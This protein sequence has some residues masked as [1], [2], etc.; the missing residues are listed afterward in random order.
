MKFKHL[1]IASLALM[2]GASSANA[3][4]VPGDYFIQNVESGRFLNGAN[5]WGTKASVTKHGQKMTIAVSGS[6]YTIDSHI[7]NGS[8][9]NFLAAGDNTYTDGV[10]ATHTITDLGD[11]TFSIKDT[12]NKY[13]I[14]NDGTKVNFAADNADANTAKWKF[15]SMDD[16][17]ALMGTAKVQAPVDATYYIGDA[18]FSRN[19]Q[20]YSNWVWAWGESN[21]KQNH[22]K[23]GNN[24]NNVV[25]SFHA[26][27]SLTQ[28]ITVPNGVYAVTAQGFYRQDG[29]NNNDLPYFFANDE[30]KQL[31]LKTGSEN[32]MADA[33]TSFSNDLY[34][35]EPIYVKVTDGTLNIGVNNMNNDALWVIFDNF[36]MKYYG[37]VTIAEV[38]LAEY[39]KAYNEAMDAVNAINQEY[40]SEADKAALNTLVTENTVDLASATQEQLETAAANLTAAVPTYAYK[41]QVGALA[42]MGDNT[43]F[44]S[45][46]VNPSFETGNMSGWTNNSNGGMW[47]MMTR[48]NA[49]DPKVGN[50]WIEKYAKDGRLDISQVVRGL[51]MGQYRVSV[52]ALDQ[53]SKTKLVAQCGDT[54]V[55]TLIAGG[56]K[57]TYTA[58]I[59]LD[60]NSDLTIGLY[61]DAHNTNSWVGV[62]NFQLTYLTSELPALPATASGVMNATVEQ[63]QADA[64]AAYNANKSI[65]TYNAAVAAIDA[66]QKSVAMYAANATALVNQKALIDG[67]NVYAAE[68][69][70]AYVT[71]YEAAKTAH[72]NRTATE[73]VVNPNLATGWHAST[74]YNFLLTPWTF[75]GEAC[76]EFA[77]D[78]HINTWSTEGDNDGSNFQVPFFEFWI[79][80]GENLPNKELAANV[81]G[82]ENGLYS[83]SA[84]VRVRAKNGVAANEATGI[85]L[86]VND[87]SVIDATEGA[88]VGA[89]QFTLANVTAEGLVKDG[90][91]NIKL[92][93][94]NT[95][96][97]W[98]AFKNV[99]YNKVRD[100]LPEE[101]IVYATTEEIA[102]FN[103]AIAAAE[104]KT[105]GFAEGEYAP[106]NNIA[107]VAALKA[108]K[109]LDVVNPIDIEVLAPAKDALDNAVWT[110]NEEEVNAIYDSGFSKTTAQAG[111]YL[112]PTGW[113]N[114]G[115][116]TRVYNQTNKGSN[117]GIDAA[118]EG[119]CLFA[120]FTTTYGEVEGYEMPLKA[121]NY[122]LKFIYGGW[123]EVGTRDIKVYNAE[124]NAVVTP[125]TVTAINNQAHVSTDAWS[126]YEGMITIPADGNYVLSF[127]RQSTN[128][129]NQI[130]ISDIEIY[131]TSVPSSVART[132][133][134]E[135]YG[136]I[137]L[138]YAAK[139]TGATVYSAAIEGDEVVLTEVGTN[140]VAGTPYI[141]QATADEQTFAYASGNIVA[142]P[143]AAGPLTGVFTATPAPVGSYVLQTQNGEQKFYIV[144]AAQPTVSAFKAYVNAP[145]A[146]AK[147]RITLGEQTGI[148]AINAIMNGTA[149]IYDL[150]GRQLKSLQKGVNIVNGAKVIVK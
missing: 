140:L 133:A 26:Q 115:Y 5:D 22:N 65:A 29:S 40:L 132:I 53:A 32:S 86:A 128:A 129:Q 139:A 83:V 110:V 7:S 70:N 103:E 91:L 11:G 130:A 108:A 87:G 105:L 10:A 90:V 51:P 67:T 107:A 113:T 6:G 104:A 68:G 127:Y 55:E 27:F 121:G 16:V 102:A 95:N 135:K 21:N 28:T 19:N 63:A 141:Y 50:Y 33:S 147:L 99:T 88:Q 142:A 122:T 116:N 106:Y 143:V 120:K 71:A 97:S 144:G 100:L 109:A 8:G 14:Q 92:N 149:K 24:D 75:G 137:C 79:A 138:P 78:L 47:T 126:T 62:D 43:E 94:E 20:Y 9:K 31:S 15:I 123:N 117:N 148:N 93:V 98:L 112:V 39:V 131:S 17:A 61:C 37:D 69:Y 59:M 57:A 81:T 150:N 23:A 124:N 49:A 4:F 42:A 125:V 66:A 96:I 136:T 146:P 114:L 30:K 54:K 60:N 64:I 76:N 41:A 77:K 12:N 25:E 38:L 18:N 2:G 119:G 46:L 89:S 84:L 48:A 44:T 101:Q 82:L 73:A 111:G 36:E 80:D 118:S 72:D 58:D 145:A 35:I 85:T 45:L 134:S 74:A 13:L 34:T 56:D 52:L 3:Q 1:L